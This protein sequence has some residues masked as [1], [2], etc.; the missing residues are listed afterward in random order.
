[1]HDSSP[2]SGTK[3]L[4]PKP[5]LGAEA[6]R[7]K[8]MERIDAQIHSFDAKPAETI[9]ETLDVN[10]K[11]YLDVFL[12]AMDDSSGLAQSEV[13][14]AKVPMGCYGRVKEAFDRHK[15]QVNTTAK[16]SL[17][18]ALK[19]IC[20]AA[21]GSLAAQRNDLR[22]MFDEQL[23]LSLDEIAK[24][25]DERVAA[26]EAVTK[27]AKQEVQ[28]VLYRSSSSEAIISKCE[29]TLKQNEEKLDKQSKK[30]NSLE[31]KIKKEVADWESNLKDSLSL[32]TLKPKKDTAAQDPSSFLWKRAQRSVGDQLMKAIDQLESYGEK[33]SYIVAAYE[34]AKRRASDSRKDDKEEAAAE[35]ELH[36]EAAKKRELVWVEER[37]QLEQQIEELK[38]VTADEEQQ[39]QALKDKSSTIHQVAKDAARVQIVK[40]E[41]EMAT[42]KAELKELQGRIETKD[43]E[44]KVVAD[45]RVALEESLREAEKAHRAEHEALQMK[46][47]TCITALRAS[48]SASRNGGYFF[49]AAPTT[50]WSFDAMQTEEMDDAQLRQ[51]TWAV[52]RANSKISPGS[53]SSD[54][55]GSPDGQ[56]ARAP[57]GS[58]SPIRRSGPAAPAPAAS[59]SNSPELAKT[60]RSGMRKSLTTART[61]K[62]AKSD[63][64]LLESGKLG[65]VPTSARAAAT[66]ART[67]SA[68]R[69]PRKPAPAMEN[70]T[71]S[72]QG[73]HRSGQSGAAP[74]PAASNHLQHAFAL[75]SVYVA[76]PASAAVPTSLGLSSAPAPA[77]APSPEVAPKLADANQE[78]VASLPRAASS[79]DADIGT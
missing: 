22:V 66:S 18:T 13:L 23:K 65:P 51:V 68:R 43:A 27:E 3:K 71:A 10:G 52:T 57:N 76:A 77:E 59:A 64:K 58:T 53:P 73:D 38:G 50:Q 2:A 9:K 19:E 6:V 61:G 30:L 55:S 49:S 24:D 54:P 33:L 74:A 67:Q 7:A 14:A 21:I 5:S 37:Q 36:A 78:Q 44:V 15:L 29:Q 40:L 60:K 72:A 11:Q 28:R 70:S 62:V 17:K 45:S 35:L 12:K 75:E 34:D 39:I 32:C 79:S 47:N 8:T 48:Q 4:P 20:D 26:A 69:Q 56:Q 16:D 25:R 42:L 1:M 31:E 41:G 63:V 46:L